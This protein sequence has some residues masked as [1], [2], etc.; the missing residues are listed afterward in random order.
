[1][2]SFR[3][4]LGMMPRGD[5]GDEGDGHSCS[6]SDD[7]HDNELSG[8]MVKDVAPTSPARGVL[9]PGDVI[10]EIDGIPVANDGK[11]P[12]RPGE[13][14]AVACYLQT[15]FVGDSVNLRV[16]R[17]EEQIDLDC[18]VGVVRPKVPAHFDNR[19]PPYLIVA[20]LVFTALSIPY[21]EAS[22]A[23]EE[24]VSAGMSYLL[25]KVSEPLERGTDQVVILSQVL[26]HRENLGYDQLSDLHLEKL[27][28]Q[29]VRSLAHL[30]SLI[31]NS[32]DERFLR[33]EFQPK[34]RIVILERSK[35][36]KA[37]QDV[38]VEQ[39]IQKSHYFGEADWSQDAGGDERG[40]EEARVATDFE[41][42]A[43]ISGGER[44]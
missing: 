22:G 32:K 34:D 43:A 37:T 33:F 26:A 24:Y 30:N 27:N 19:P 3:K 5:V 2:Q 16:L 21:L 38:C 14:V 1:M 25:G 41:A 9:L 23:W 12:F 20:G 17:E 13:R 39:S 36:E 6:G 31:Q 44:A 10:L 40:K 28:G 7:D 11:V 4:S 29:S 35:V 42:K 8:V 15:K 18:P